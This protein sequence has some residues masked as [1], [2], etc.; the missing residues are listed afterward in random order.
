M[1]DWERAA[2]RL[3]AAGAC[4]AFATFCGAPVMAAWTPTGADI[5][6]RFGMGS[7]L[8]TQT[9][10]TGFGDN[11]SELDQL[12][13]KS[14]GTDLNIGITGNIE[15]NGNGVVILLDT[16]SGG[17]SIFN[18]TGMDGSNRIN[19][20]NGDTLNSDFTPHYA[21]DVNHY[22]GTLYVD[23]YDL[24]NNTK[25]Y[26][27]N[28]TDGGGAGALTGGGSVAFDN[29][30]TAGVSDT[31]ATDGTGYPLAASAT[32]G[33]EL[34]IPLEQ[35]GATSDDARVLAVLVGGP[36]GVSN[37][38]LPGL[39]DTTA[40]LGT[41]PINFE[42]LPGKYRARVGLS[43]TANDLPSTSVPWAYT[44]VF[45]SGSKDVDA[46][47]PVTSIPA[48]LNGVAYVAED[49]EDS[50]GNH[51][52][53][54]VAI[55]AHDTGTAHLVTTF[56]TNGRVTGLDGPVKAR[57]AAYYSGGV[58]RL[59]A[60]TG[61]GTLY[62]MDADTGGNL[63]SVPV[64][65]G[66]HSNC[67][68]AV[69]SAGGSVDIIV[70]GAGS[71]NTAQLARIPDLPT[72]AVSGTLSLSGFNNALSPSA[73]S[74]GSRIQVAV[75]GTDQTGGHGAVYTIDGSNF[76]VFNSATTGASIPATPTLT[77][78][79]AGLMVVGAF[80]RTGSTI[81]AFNASNAN[82][83]WSVP[84]G[85]Y[86][87]DGAFVDY[88][89]HPNAAFFTVFQGIPGDPSATG[90]LTAVSADTGAPLAGF[91]ADNF[92]MANVSP[93]LLKPSADGAQGSAY[94]PTANGVYVADA[95]APS[96][97]SARRF[98]IGGFTATLSATGTAS[99]DILAATIGVGAAEPSELGL[100]G[101]ISGNVYGLAVQ[102]PQPT[103]PRP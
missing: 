18:Y 98:P 2:R 96:A 7:L 70:S 97:T 84:V 102:G 90:S 56:G 46:H 99:G 11:K 61:N 28:C 59:Y 78:E 49:V 33:V 101:T 17:S 73:I 50:A 36:G 62:V 16:Q 37:Q 60:M 45:L 67:T 55:D 25:T 1:R 58:P 5:P 85:G 77:R 15:D 10:P 3:R 40:N 74:D 66:G 83:V 82:L 80:D 22:G 57:I 8:A 95:A 87:L 65:P 75:F 47:P 20:L 51:T 76:T 27:G 53:N 64:F 88:K 14:D 32:T 35:V 48:V 9:V 23:L 4:A 72:L 94:I 42:N 79:P 54:I 63:R 86:I 71:D 24:V 91:P 29:S 69:I 30:N 103:E 68:P 6:A 31:A 92:P 34:S 41:G 44:P 39:P 93:L 89:A 26:L 21:V 100:A 81:S 19:A 13:V 43:I 52:G 38:S 12:F